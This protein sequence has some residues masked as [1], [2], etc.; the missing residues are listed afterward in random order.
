M[1]IA[2]YL[3]LAANAIKSQEI[4]VTTDIKLRTRFERLTDKDFY[5]PDADNFSSF[6]T[7]FE[8]G[9][10]VDYG[11]WQFRSVYQFA[12]SQNW[13]ASG[14]S[15]TTNS[16]LNEFYLKHTED[17]QAWTIGRQKFEINDGR[18]VATSDWGNVSRTFDGIHFEN[19]DFQAFFIKDAIVRGRSHD[20]RLAGFSAHHAGGNSSYFFKSDKT[21]S[22][23]TAIHTLDRTWK[24]K[25][26]GNATNLEIA[27]QFGESAGKEHAAYALHADLTMPV[28]KKLKLT[29]EGNLASG[30]QSAT[31]SRTFDELSASTHSK[32]GYMDM[33]GW[34]NMK[35]IALKTKYTFNA[36]T[37]LTANIH[38]FW[39]F[40]A[41]DGFYRSSSLNKGPGGNF[42]DPTGMSGTHLGTE[43]NIEVNHAF[44]WADL[45][46]GFGVFEP[47]N[48]IKNLNG[49]SAERQ[50]YFYTQ[51]S[52]K[53]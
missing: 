42:I 23:N 9:F 39:L 47:G 20:A 48:F 16:D 17:G 15:S 34:R 31:H 18:L 14:D 27:V 26:G 37:S 36:R 52:F 51:L 19:G 1:P 33:V 50:L 21:S 46:A 40:D 25:L 41:A 5:E 2:S 35:E 44:N 11:Q 38:G 12:N 45:K 28:S 13:M 32:Y 3:I 6:L 49:G 30:G 24:S 7:R 29:F 22:G 8:P 53:F 10:T 43:L 4:K